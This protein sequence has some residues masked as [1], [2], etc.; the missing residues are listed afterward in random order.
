MGQREHSSRGAT[1]PALYAATMRM[2][3]LRDEQRVM[4]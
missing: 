3:H 2:R 1:Q 4:T